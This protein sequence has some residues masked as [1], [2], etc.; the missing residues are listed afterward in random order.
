MSVGEKSKCKFV[1]RMSNKV[2]HLQKDAFVKN[3]L[4]ELR[5]LYKSRKWPF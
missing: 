1:S 4:L 2:R 3:I 5:N